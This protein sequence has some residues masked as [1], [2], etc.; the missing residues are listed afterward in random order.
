V[1]A[2]RWRIGASA[3][4]TAVVALAVGHGDVRAQQAPD[5]GTFAICTTP[6][7]CALL[8]EVTAG[9]TVDLL[10]SFTAGDAFISGTLAWTIPSDPPGLPD[11]QQH[12]AS[13]P[14]YVPTALPVNQFC[15]LTSPTASGRTI[16]EFLACSS[17]G[18]FTVEYRRVT[19]PTRA[20]ELVI[21]TTF[22]AGEAPGLGTATAVLAPPKL[23]ILPAPASRLAFAQ[24]PTT[25]T[26]GEPMDPGVVVE[27][28]D[29][30]G[31]VVAD[32][33]ATVDLSLR[34]PSGSAT[35]NGTTS[36]GVVGGTTSF[37]DLSVDKAESGDRLVASSG[38]LTGAAS[39][40]FDIRAGPPAQLAF[41][42]QPGGTASRTQPFPDQPRVDV[43]DAKG[44]LVPG[45]ASVTLGIADGSGPG[46][47]QLT[48][49]GGLTAAVS[50]GVATFDGCAID[51]GGNGYRLVAT[52]ADA[53]ATSDPFDVTAVL[54]AAAPASAAWWRPAAAAGTGGLI[55]LLILAPLAW[56]LTHR[57][58]PQ[59]HAVRA[60]LH[61]GREAAKVEEPTPATVHS[62]RATTR[63]GPVVLTV[64]EER[65]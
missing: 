35:L 50:Q 64:Q 30:Y 6:D 32:S 60:E 3:A 39:N 24:Q 51:T 23:D 12:D 34:S 9:S 52:A 27:V 62:I 47:A 11:P 13:Q 14:G 57:R 5:P 61:P 28:E 46:G 31:N 22:A 25:T 36:N 4:V 20:G 17:G 56:K 48:C 53:M 55:L 8:F 33:E 63:V 26:A 38:K 59:P 58:R 65:R 7:N 19:I 15:K 41:A 43:R 45:D 29:R 44:N 16:S 1:A 10:L 42:G 49:S 18:S 40:P 21:P 2:G 54:V 37:D